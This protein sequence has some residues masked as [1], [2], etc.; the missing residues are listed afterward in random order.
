[1]FR[2]KILAKVWWG[3]ILH[4]GNWFE[5]GLNDFLVLSLQ[6]KKWIKEDL[7]KKQRTSLA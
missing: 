7:I 1:M 5:W 4:S 3:K 2:G 6:N